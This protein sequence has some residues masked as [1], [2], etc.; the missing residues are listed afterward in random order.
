MKVL[1]RS[2]EQRLHQIWAQDDAAADADAEARQETE[3]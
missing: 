1:E 2:L 3:I